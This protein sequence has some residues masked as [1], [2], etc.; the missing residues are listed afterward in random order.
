[1]LVEHAWTDKRIENILGNLLRAGV[2]VS[3]VIVFCGAVIY[4][5][6]HGHETADFRVFHGSLRSCAGYP[7]LC[8]TPSS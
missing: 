6:R 2:I 8:A 5:A 7:A 4:L 3:A 1:M